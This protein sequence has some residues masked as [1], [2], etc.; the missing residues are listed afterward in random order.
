M[1]RKGVSKRK[2]KKTK[3]KEYAASIASGSISVAI[4]AA[5]DQHIKSFEKI[6]NDPVKKGSEKNTSDRKK[7]SRKG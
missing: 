2:P 5:D 3:S 4:R 1:G 6:K 7:N